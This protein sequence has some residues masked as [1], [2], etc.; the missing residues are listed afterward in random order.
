MSHRSRRRSLGSDQ[1]WQRLT[2]Q[3]EPG[4][5]PSAGVATLPTVCDKLDVARD[6]V[7][8]RPVCRVGLFRTLMPQ[9]AVGLH[10]GVD[11]VEP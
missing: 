8:R 3:P 1:L 11:F 5:G 6:V 10:G 9:P 2:R 7:A 4:P